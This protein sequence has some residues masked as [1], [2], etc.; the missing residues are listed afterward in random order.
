MHKLKTRLALTLAACSLLLITAIAAEAQTGGD[1]IYACYQKNSGDLRKVSGPGQCKNSEIQISWSLSGLPGPQG[2]QGPAGPQ[3]PQGPAGP[4]GQQGPQGIQ[5]PQGEQ[6][7]TGATGAAGAAGAQGPQ[8]EAGQSV[9]SVAIPLGDARCPNGVGG[10][11]YTDSTGVRVVC[12]GQQ[13]AQGEKGEK[14]ETGAP[15]TG[16]APTFYIRELPT[17]SANK[18]SQGDTVQVFSCLDGDQVTGGGYTASPFLI[19]YETRP[20][21]SKTWRISMK[22]TTESSL[23]YSMYIVC[24]DLTP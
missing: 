13:G 20:L 19:V 7:A 18:A 1:I 14:G 5:G 9:T 22:N 3:G 24:M 6:G 15:G 23:G 16:A 12:N 21:D 17:R 4:Q 2:P 11:E 10:V 8:G